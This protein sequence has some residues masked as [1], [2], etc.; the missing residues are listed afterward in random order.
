MLEVRLQT[1]G[2]EISRFSRRS[3]PKEYFSRL[4]KSGLT[5][6][7]DCHILPPRLME[8]SLLISSAVE[9]QANH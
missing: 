1:L 5:A 7:A 4:S 8:G 9:C 2:A 3:L 6:V